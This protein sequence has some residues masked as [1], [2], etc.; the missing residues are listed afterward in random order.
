VGILLIFR[1]N[2]LKKFGN[3]DNISGK[4]RVKFGHFDNFSR[5][6]FRQKC[7]VPLKL[8]EPMKKVSEMSSVI[9]D[10]LIVHIDDGLMM[11]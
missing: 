11:D 5:I 8:I 10:T 4:N 6:F 2:I 1:A 7:C 9:W 3:F